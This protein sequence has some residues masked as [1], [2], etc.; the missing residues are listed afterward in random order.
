MEA[1]EAKATMLEQRRMKLRP[2]LYGAA[3]MTLFTGAHVA[4]YAGDVRANQE[5]QA[6]STASV[7]VLDGALDE[8]HNNNAIVFI[9]G[10]GT[11]N[12]DILTKYMGRAVQPVIDGQLWSVDYN[13]AALSYDDIAE[14]VIDTAGRRGVTSISFVGYSA[15]CPVSMQTNEKVAELSNLTVESI[16]MVSCPDG[17]QGLR[18]AR[19]DEIDLAERFKWIPGA[20]YSTPIRFMGELAMRSGSFTHGEDMYDN[21]QNFSETATRVKEAFDN[22]KLPGTW[23]MFDQLFAIE[24]ANINDRISNIAKQ[25]DTDV[26]P[27]IVYV[28]TAKPGYDYMV[29]D[30]YSSDNIGKYTDAADIPYFIENVPGAVHT[31][32]DLANDE[33]ILTLEGAKVG[34]QN[35]IAT[36]T[37]IA[38]ANKQL[39]RY[40][41]NLGSDSNR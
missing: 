34:I 41:H 7:R 37:A 29:D 9:D 17:A 14:S 21:V 13:N 25:P 33:Y 38:N 11:N 15:G 1:I 28:G 40:E 6:T 31:R 32:I 30:K 24:N 8:V 36:Q 2:Y 22:N 39:K 4:A 5:I 35:S 23:L 12:A 20:Q 3:A 19:Q 27:T 26:R 18:Q 16:F 10:F